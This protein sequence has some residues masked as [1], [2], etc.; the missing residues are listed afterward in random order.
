MRRCF[1]DAVRRF[2]APLELQCCTASSTNGGTPNFARNTSSKGT[3]SFGIDPSKLDLALNLHEADFG[4]MVK[5]TKAAMAKDKHHREAIAGEVFIGNDATAEGEAAPAHASATASPARLTLATPASAAA[6]T[7]SSSGSGGD[8]GNA[9]MMSRT[10]RGIVGAGAAHDTNSLHVV[11]QQRKA[12]GARY[13]LMDSL[14]DCLLAGNWERGMRLFETAL[15]TGCKSVQDTAL[16][17]ESAES[18]G[19]ETLETLRRINATTPTNAVS[20]NLPTHRGILRWGGGHFYMLLK[21]LLSKH[22]VTEAERVWDVMKRIGFVEFHMDARTIN[23]CIAMARRTTS[24]DIISPLTDTKKYTEDGEKAFRRT[25]VLELEDWAK[26]KGL[27]LDGRNKHAAQAARFADALKNENREGDGKSSDTAINGEGLKVGDFGGL[28]R[29]C[30]SE[31][32]TARVLHMMEKLKVP[33][34]GNIYSSLIAALRQPHYC[35]NGNDK[36]LD[37]TVTK[38]EYDAHRRKRL[39][40]ARQ[41]YEECPESERTADVYNEMLHITRGGDEEDSGFERL[42]V[43]FRGVP[44]LLSAGSPPAGDNASGES[45]DTTRG[46]QQRPTLKP[47]QWRTPPNG[48]TYEILVHR[49]RH[50][51]DWPVMWALYDEMMEWHVVGTKRL[52]E[53]LLEVAGHHPPQGME[54]HSMVM[55]LYEDMKRRGIDVTGIKSTVSVVNAWSATRR[56]RRW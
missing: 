20:M 26:K 8:D 54:P 4:A 25:F 31:E 50:L 49:S 21:L 11:K 1:V 38:E 46:K 28:L 32:S 3:A 36:R 35:L 10:V 42:L 48:R 2:A 33:R 30:T 17:T 18:E 9:W 23:Q 56:R 22:R 15:E 45:E 40:R 52:Y 34:K 14:R 24:S 16:A 43:E 19:K 53:T 7:T 55:E 51:Q 6:T 5:A 41:W 27:Q 12:E 13:G 29:R 39:E 47:P 37:G 44:L